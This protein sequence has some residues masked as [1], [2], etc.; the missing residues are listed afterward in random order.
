[1][2]DE[3]YELCE[4]LGEGGMGIV[5]RARDLCTGLEVALKMMKTRLGETGQ[6]RFQREFDA[7]SAVR[8]PHCIQVL[9]LGATPD[10]Y[11]WQS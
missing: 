11:R 6:K 7:V 1:L 10:G 2:L 3:R 4:K 5:Y 9:D 8:H